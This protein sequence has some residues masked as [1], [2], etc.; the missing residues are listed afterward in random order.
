MTMVAGFSDR[1]YKIYRSVDGDLSVGTLLLRV[2]D[3][4]EEDGFDFGQSFQL[5]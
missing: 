5:E 4:P 3:V 1:Y 2:P